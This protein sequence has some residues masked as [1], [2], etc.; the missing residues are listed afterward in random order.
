MRVLAIDWGKKKIGLA[1]GNTLSKNIIPI[2]VFLNNS[3]IFD[4][5]K[6]IIKSYGVKKIVIGK[7]VFTKTYQVVPFFNEILEFSS[8]LTDFLKEND[9]DL[10]IE[11]IEEEY[12]TFLAYDSLINDFNLIG[13]KRG[14]KKR[15]KKILSKL[16]SYSAVWILKSYMGI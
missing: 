3:L 13:K 11:Y 2:G 14:W 1:I 16:D 7:P 12:T 5:I 9:I 15:F 10:E 4:K 6:D 8:K